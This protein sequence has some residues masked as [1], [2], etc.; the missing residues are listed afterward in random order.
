MLCCDSVVVFVSTNSSL[1]KCDRF[2]MSC[3][4]SFLVLFN[5][6]LFINVEIKLLFPVL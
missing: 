3:C 2:C 1:T 6:S 5:L 4:V